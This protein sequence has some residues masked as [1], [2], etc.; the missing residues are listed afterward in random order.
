MKLPE[1]QAKELLRRYDIP[2]PVGRLA[3]SPEQAAAAAEELGGR[4]AVKAQVR[5][6]GRGKAGGIAVVDG[7]QAAA[8]AAERLLAIELNGEQVGS[9]LVEQ[10]VDIDHERYLAVAIDPSAGRPM[11]MT[12]D[13]GGVEVEAMA[14]DI[15][16]TVLAAGDRGPTEVIPAAVYRL[17]TDLDALLVEINPLA[18]TADGRLIALDAK[19]EL[20]DSAAYRH[21]QLLDEIGIAEDVDVSGTE[22]ER[23]AAAMGLRLIELGGDIAVLA[24]GAGLTMATMDAIVAAGGAPANFL[25]IGGDAYTKATPA[26]ELVLSQPG[27]RSLLVNF[28]GA[29]ARCDVMTAGVIEAWQALQPD[30]PVSFSIAGTGMDEAA[31]MVRDRLGLEPHPTMADA[32]RAAVEASGNGASQ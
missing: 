17:F 29:F 13:R 18:V 4:V 2:T 30:L 12:S 16:R 19:I 9:V 11:L 6:G 31:A 1:H 7:P 26:L 15:E 14:D 22:R 5:S 23:Q 27:V 25:E 28:C 8:E 21:R 20:D 10:A 32:V 24:N 3:T